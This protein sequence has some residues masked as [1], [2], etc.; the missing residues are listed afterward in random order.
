MNEDSGILAGGLN[1]YKA[2]LACVSSAMVGNS[3]QH[4]NESSPPSHQ[5]SIDQNEDNSVDAN[6]GI[7]LGFSPNFNKGCIP[8]MK[9]I[10]EQ[11]FNTKRYSF[12]LDSVHSL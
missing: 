7:V 4:D 10:A 6:D 12:R 3:V 9:S 5:N 1:R 11:G 8:S 2:L